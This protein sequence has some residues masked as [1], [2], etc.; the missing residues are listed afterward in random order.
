MA[1][2]FNMIVDRERDTFH[3]KLEGDFDGSSALE[4]I[5]A[6]VENCGSAKRVFIHTNGLGVVHPFGKAVFQRHFPLP[7]R[8]SPSIIFIGE[9]AEDIAP[10]S[11]GESHRRILMQ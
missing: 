10:S 5:H 4:V 1:A 8:L 6:L 3:L 11:K 2:N 7:G 9:H